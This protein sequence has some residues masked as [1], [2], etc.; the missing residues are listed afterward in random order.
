VYGPVCPVVWE[1]QSR[2]ALPYPDW[3]SI[4]IEVATLKIVALNDET[5]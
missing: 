4:G 1:G 5:N 3:A 2:K